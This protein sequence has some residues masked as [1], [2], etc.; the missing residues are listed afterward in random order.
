MVQLDGS[1]G[2]PCTCLMFMKPTDKVKQMLFLWL[3]A[4]S[5][6]EARI[7]QVRLS[8]TGTSWG[9]GESDACL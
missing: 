3:K 6:A 8:P 2:N 5:E 9:M 7:N 4:A 1:A